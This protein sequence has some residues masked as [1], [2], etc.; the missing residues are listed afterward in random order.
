LEQARAERK[1][2]VAFAYGKDCAD[3]ERMEKETLIARDV[4]PWIDLI[5]VTVRFHD[6]DPAG[7]AFTGKYQ[8]HDFPTLL[9]FANDG[10]ELGRMP[11]FIDGKDFRSRVDALLGEADIF[12]SDPWAGTDVVTAAADR[13]GNYML[14][15]RYEEAQTWYVWCLRHRAA[16]APNFLRLNLPAIVD[17]LASLAARFE[18]AKEALL[19]EIH[20][21]ERD[22]LD[23]HKMEA[24]PFNL[25]KLGYLALGQESRIVEHYDLL[26]AAAPGTSKL[27]AFAKF[28]FEPLLNAHRYKEIEWSVAD[29]QD[30]VVF[31]D[32]ARNLQRPP[33]YIH[34]V[35]GARYEVL[36]GLGRYGGAAEMATVWL[37][38]DKSWQT[39]LALA[40][41]GLRSGAVHDDIPEH[42]REARA[43]CAGT[44]PRPF[45]C[46]A[47]Y[48]RR[49]NPEDREAIGVL[50]S[51]MSSVA[52]DK[53][54][55][56][57]V[58]CLNEFKGAPPSA[59][60]GEKEK[61]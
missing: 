42:A 24:F 37:R 59:K 43:L 29:E 32:E 60:P 26:A 57:I 61:H 47:R 5:A 36:M 33:G 48:L 53:G 30:M 54:R 31:M 4:R 41:A 3:C 45:I 9:I 14:Q 25:I 52:T 17:G 35:L 15:S 19:N 23:P 40:E 10:L 51:A 1:Y 16:R 12:K 28:I 27:E 11:G 39:Y 56:S 34:K 58:D 44:D 13:A 49:V 7:R 20:R 2:V 46:L 55:Q 18:P 22:S 50:E 6:Q 38:Y 8:L 21:A